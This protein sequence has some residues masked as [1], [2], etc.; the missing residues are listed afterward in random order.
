MQTSLAA[1]IKETPD[2]KTA[3]RILRSCVHCGFCNATC[4]TYE[5]L[6]DELDGPRGRIYLIKDILEGQ[7]HGRN[8]QVHLDRCLTCRACETTCPSGVEYGR[9]LDIGRAQ[10]EKK[11]SRPWHERL[12]RYALRKVVPYPNRIRAIL[13][14]AGF[15][16]PVLP[17][18][19]KNRLPT[20]GKMC[21]P[22]GTTGHRRKMLLLDGC[23]QPILMPS[24]NAA[25][26]RLL[27]KLGIDLVSVKSAGCCGAVSHHLSATKEAKQWMQRNIDAWWPHIEQGAEAVVV[28]AS[29]CATMVKDY[30]YLL[31]HDPQYADKARRVSSM[32]KD[33][34]EIVVA[35]NPQKLARPT[36][37]PRRI[38][39][40]S[41]CSLQH[42][43]K[44]DGVV[45]GLLQAADFELAPIRDGHLC[46]GSAGTYSLLQPSLADKLLRR[47]V[48]CLEAG[49]PEMIV[50]ANIGCYLHLQKQLSIPIMHWVELFG[51]KGPVG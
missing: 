17:K 41:P 20:V 24:I 13:T 39:F 48:K 21:S 6:G 34:A 30:G 43:Q 38:A 11:V 8:T 19:Y 37:A 50:T 14:M 29:G 28:T 10:V 35:E 16:R 27:D 42:G 18:R 4:P 15:I 26:T 12:V 22:S 44:L 36:W 23:A 9:L 46:C 32:A 1:S 33:I 47:K 31:R 45:E 5:L 40:Q 7:P 51:G 3:D 49:E 2:G 25:T